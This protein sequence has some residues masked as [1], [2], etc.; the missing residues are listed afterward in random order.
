MQQRLCVRAVLS[1][2]R[3]ELENHFAT[4]KAIANS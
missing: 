3:G 2:L 4:A 1:G